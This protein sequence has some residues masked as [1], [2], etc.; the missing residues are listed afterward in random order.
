[1]RV[2]K[3]TRKGPRGAVLCYRH[4]YAEF[5]D[6]NERVRRLRGF[7]DKGATE[8]AGRKLERLAAVRASRG[9]PDLELSRFLSGLPRRMRE[10]LAE[11]DMI[12][13]RRLAAGERLEALLDRFADSLRASDVTEKHVALVKGRVRRAFEEAGFRTLGDIDA[14]ELARA[15]HRLREDRRDIESGEV[16]PGISARTSNHHLAATK[17]FTRWA[18]D[19]RLA[20]EDPLRSLRPLNARVDPRRERRA[21]SWNDELPRLVK[22]AAN[23]PEHRGT[24]GPLRALVW[25]LLSETGLR[26]G[27]LVRLQMG[28]LDFDG[29]RPTLTVRAASAKNRREQTIPLRTETARELATIA[30]GR[31]PQAAALPLPK[32]FKDN[33]PRWL[34]FDLKA[35][36][37]P[38]TDDSGRVADVHALRN[39]MVSGLL[40]AGADPKSVQALAR[41]ADARMTL[42]TYAKLGRDDERNALDRLAP[43]P[44]CTPSSDQE[45]AATGTENSV[46]ESVAFSPASPC[47]PVHSCTAGNVPDGPE[48]ADSAPENGGEGGIRT[49]GPRCGDTRLAI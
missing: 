28:D 25:R 13:R 42:G 32:S 5:R 34:K 11:W 21:L 8:E 12:A 4:W 23:G 27:E 45:E 30:R 6:H 7:T 41:H 22:A 44:G 46:A 26:V 48:D 17:Q 49:R 1:M 2:F 43:L 35:A 15:L 20:T 3:P 24:S 31:M 38:Y 18:V 33:A 36:G 37:I 29:E 10:R 9:E 19:G 39:S 16:I 40:K 47:R 14:D